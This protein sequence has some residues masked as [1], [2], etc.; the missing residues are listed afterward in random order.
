[1]DNKAKQKKGCETA[2]MNEVSKVNQTKASDLQ[3]LNPE[4]HTQK[5]KLV[6]LGK[7]PRGTCKKQIVVSRD[8]DDADLR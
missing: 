5:T 6:P 1:M 7:R 2:E 3:R 8:C 4:S